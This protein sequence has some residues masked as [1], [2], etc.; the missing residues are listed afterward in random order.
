ML[1][2]CS[3]R[4]CWDA[5]GADEGVEMLKVDEVVEMLKAS[6][7]SSDVPGTEGKR[8]EKGPRIRA[9]KH[10]IDSEYIHYRNCSPLRE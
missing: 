2:S 7:G 9:V 6:T 3:R 5:E 8:K 4:G 10:P 1:R